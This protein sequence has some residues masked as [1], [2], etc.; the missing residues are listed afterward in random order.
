MTDVDVDVDLP[1]GWSER[2]AEA[3]HEPTVVEFEHTTPEETTFIVSV[4]P[5]SDDDQY[6]LR[7]S[8]FNPTSNY[9]RHDYPVEVYNARTDAVTEAGSLVEYIA[10]RLQEGSI[11]TADPDIN[12]IRDAIDEFSNSRPFSSLRRLIRRLC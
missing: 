9:A 4:L 2:P 12:V 8:I 1:E 5:R 10:Q 11:S 7:L 3:H 6:R